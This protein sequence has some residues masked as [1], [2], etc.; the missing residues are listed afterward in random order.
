[1]TQQCNKLV[2]DVAIVARA[3][4]RLYTDEGSMSGFCAVTADNGRIVHSFMTDSI[5]IATSVIEKFVLR[6]LIARVSLLLTIRTNAYTSPRFRSFVTSI[7]LL[8]TIAICNPRL[9][10]DDW[11][12]I[13]ERVLWERLKIY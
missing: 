5:T 8:L 3:P 10:F 2:H 9:K 11:S 6:K 13:D 4:I 12:Y 7:P 1:M